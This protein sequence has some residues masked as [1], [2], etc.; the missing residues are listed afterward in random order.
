M[1]DELRKALSEKINPQ[2]TAYGK[3]NPA[4]PEFALCMRLSSII[5]MSKDLSSLR[6]INSIID[7]KLGSLTN[8]TLIDTLKEMQALVGSEKTPSSSQ[9]LSSSCSTTEIVDDSS[10]QDDE[11]LLRSHAFCGTPPL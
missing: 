2:V 5:N 4:S 3:E 6:Q 10:S 1:L 8:Q 11:P 9:E 7:K